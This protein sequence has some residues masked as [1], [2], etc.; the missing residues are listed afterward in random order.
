MLLPIA[1]PKAAALGGVACT[2]EVGSIYSYAEIMLVGYS[3]GTGLTLKLLLFVV[4]LPSW[5]AH[6]QLELTPG[7]DCTT[8]W[9]CIYGEQPPLEPP[10]ITPNSACLQVHLPLNLPFLLPWAMC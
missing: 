10:T 8:L 9:A 6:P 3:A 5:A 2:L 1:S 4:S 7:A